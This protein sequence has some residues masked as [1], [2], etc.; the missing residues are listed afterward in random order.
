MAWKYK[1][2]A[3]ALVVVAFARRDTESGLPAGSSR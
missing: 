1:S 3:L 2:K